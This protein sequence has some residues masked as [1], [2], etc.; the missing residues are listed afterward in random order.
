MT[1]II[2]S[3]AVS[4]YFGLVILLI[5]RKLAEDRANDPDPRMTAWLR[6]HP[7]RRHIPFLDD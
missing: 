1:A 6:T 5:R 2:I 3:A 4:V 7:R